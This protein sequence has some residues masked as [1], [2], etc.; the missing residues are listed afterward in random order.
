MPLSSAL[1]FH[2]SYTPEPEL[3]S[4]DSPAF[5]DG[6]LRQ[7]PPLQLTRP[8]FHLAVSAITGTLII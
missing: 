3:S 7:L 2:Q 5:Q 6:G 8:S 4:L 1:A